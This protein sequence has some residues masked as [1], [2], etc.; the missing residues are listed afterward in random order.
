MTL[1]ILQ[2]LQKAFTT[3]TVSGDGSRIA[4][5]TIFVIIND[6]DEGFGLFVSIIFIIVDSGSPFVVRRLLVCTSYF[7]V[8]VSSKKYK[9]KI[10][11]GCH[12]QSVVSSFSSLG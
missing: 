12:G 4:A 2:S 8:T 6:D 10:C 3:D 9:C 11:F 5:R 7:T 1:E